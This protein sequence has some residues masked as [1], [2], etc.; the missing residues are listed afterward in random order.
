MFCGTN[1]ENLIQCNGVPANSANVCNSYT[2]TTGR[3]YGE[4]YTCYNVES[5]SINVC[6]EHGYCYYSGF[7]STGY[8]SS[9]SGKIKN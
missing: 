8:C 5:S 4:T 2:Q 1:C 9:Y 7:S 6:S 3:Y